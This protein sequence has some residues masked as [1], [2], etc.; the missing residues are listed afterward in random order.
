MINIV[1]H[2]KDLDGFV[3]GALALGHYKTYEKVNMVGWNYG[4]PIPELKGRIVMTDIS[5]PPEDMLRLKDNIIL[6]IDHHQSAIED[7]KDFQYDHLEGIRREG[8]SATRLM[9]EYLYPEDDQVLL[10]ELVDRYD[11]FKQE[12]FEMQGVTFSWEDILKFQYGLRA[13]IKDP[14]EDDGK[15][16]DLAFDTLHE[17]DCEYHASYIIGS[18]I[19]EENRKQN[20]KRGENLYVEN[21]SVFGNTFKIGVVW[22]DRPDIE[23][24]DYCEDKEVEAVEFKTLGKDGMVTVSLRKKKDSKADILALAKSYGGGGHPCACGYRYSTMA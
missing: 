10:I 14:T 16:A 22:G 3:S 24:L 19:L 21:Y 23:V 1:Y 2:N 8:D 5:F 20:K 7:S 12:D 18:A 13:L 6:W 17:T 11:V 15:S 9:H 4:D